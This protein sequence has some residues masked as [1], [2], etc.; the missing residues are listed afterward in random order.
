MN[1]D[2]FYIPA[3]K[4]SSIPVG[5]GLGGITYNRESYSEHGKYLIRQV[6][7]IKTALRTFKDFE[8]SENVY[9][10]IQ[11]PQIVKL[12]SVKNELQRMGITVTGVDPSN[13]SS[14]YGFFKKSNLDEL[15][16]I[17]SNYASLPKNPLKSYV[18]YLDSITP[19][20]ASDKLKVNLDSIDSEN[21]SFVL[22]LHSEVS[23]EK[24]DLLIGMIKEEFSVTS[25]VDK[26]FLDNN[27]KTV[28]IE[29]NKSDVLEVCNRYSLIQSISVNSRSIITQS[30]Q[31]EPL[32]SDRIV[33]SDPDNPTVIVIDSGITNGGLM[34][35]LVKYAVQSLPYGVVAPQ[36]NHGTFVASRIAFGDDLDRSVTSLEV[37]SFCN[38]IDFAVFGNYTSPDGNTSTIGPQRLELCRILQ[39]AVET[40]KDQSRVINLSLGE[41]KPIEDFVYSETAFVI[42]YLSR[43]YDVIFIIASGN[44]SGSLGSFPEDHFNSSKA[45]ICPPAESVLGVTVGAIAK[46]EDINALSIFNQVSPFSRRGPGFNRGLKPELVHHGGNLLSNYSEYARIATSGLFQTGA[47]LATDNGTSFSAPLVSQIAARLFA[48]YNGCTANLIKALLMHFADSAIPHNVLGLENEHQVGFGVPNYS[49]AVSA[50]AN[51]ASYLYEGKAKNDHFNVIKFH[52][53]GLLAADNPNTKLRVKVTV[54]SN[55]PVN[56]KDFSQYIQSRLTVSLDKLNT[57][58]VLGKTA[59]SPEDKIVADWSPIQQFEKAFSRSYSSGEWELKVRCWTRGDLTEDFEQDFAVVIEIIDDFG[60]GDPHQEILNETGNTYFTKVISLERAA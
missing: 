36:Y 1:R 15:E 55:P 58:G 6:T 49:R 52:I 21:A 46:H 43:K 34:S 48:F 19:V 59:L 51:S 53:P 27:L 17:I 20:D 8:Y 38:V 50:S 12:H 47:H 23:E 22:N 35:G 40:F 60:N 26:F 7:A 4:V 41:N 37:Q 57:M 16:S 44:I 29:L 54:V 18:K 5:K 33:I 11:S 39:N 45:R 30:L 10:K 13:S 28:S 14:G 3:S 2:H 32:E 56:Q 9:A 42:D 24:A 31:A 25:N